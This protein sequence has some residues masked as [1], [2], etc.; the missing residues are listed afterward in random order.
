MSSVT[1]VAPVIIAETGHENNHRNQ[2][3]ESCKLPVHIS[4]SKKWARGKMNP[5]KVTFSFL[6]N[7]LDSF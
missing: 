3:G 1:L 5:T 4:D 7:I 2:S 6:I